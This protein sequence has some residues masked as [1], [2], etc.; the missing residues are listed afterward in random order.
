[1]HY[2]RIIECFYRF[3][4]SSLSL[5]NVISGECR[6][7]AESEVTINFNVTECDAR[8]S[9]V[10]VEARAHFL[11]VAYR[12]YPQTAPRYTGQP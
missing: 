4:W 7:Q 1:M 10:Y 3:I 6:R 5:A 12:K 11:F 8:V 9:N 2:A